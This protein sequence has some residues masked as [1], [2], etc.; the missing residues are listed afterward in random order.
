MQNYDLSDTLS[1]NPIASVRACLDTLARIKARVPRVQCLTN[2]VAQ[3]ITANCLLAIGA[4]VSM[5]VHPE[6]IVDMVAG[7]DALLI[8][9]GTIDPLREGAIRRLIETPVVRAKPL[10]LDPVFVEAS[11]LR[12]GLARRVV[13]DRQVIIRANVDEARALRSAVS[14]DDAGRATWITTGAVDRIVSG[15]RS[16]ACTRGH[17]MMSRVTGLGCALGAIVAAFRAVE[18]DPFVACVA[19][20]E[21]FGAAGERAARHS[22]GPGSFAVAI[23]DALA[24]IDADILM[25]ETR[26]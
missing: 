22:H 10:V 6:E 13:E 18:P 8:N 11:A 1:A 4:R 14:A 20:L 2:T 9:L 3:A 21:V 12:L 25:P 26:T 7:A 19:A 24:A 23:V 16:T 15:Q 17:P 5:A